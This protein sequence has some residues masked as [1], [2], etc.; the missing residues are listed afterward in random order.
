[1]K[2]EHMINIPFASTYFM[3]ISKQTEFKKAFGPSNTRL[4]LVQCLKGQVKLVVGEESRTLQ[5][6]ELA[7]G[8]DSYENSLRLMATVKHDEAAEALLLVADFWHPDL[9]LEERKCI[10]E[11]LVKL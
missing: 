9:S 6:G 1:M 3:S 11:S 5:E 8:D 10:F 4:R 7:I 2:Q